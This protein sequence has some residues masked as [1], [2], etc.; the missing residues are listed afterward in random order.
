MP[1]FCWLILLSFAN[2]APDGPIRSIV[3]DGRT[4]TIDGAALR[5]DVH[6]LGQ[7]TA[8]PSRRCWAVLS[9]RLTI[10]RSRDV[11]VYHRS[12]VEVLCESSADRVDHV[13]SRSVQPHGLHLEDGDL[14]I[15]NRVWGW[16]RALFVDDLGRWLRVP[17]FQD[18]DAY[19]PSREV[20]GQVSEACWVVQEQFDLA[21]T[22]S[23]EA[24]RDVGVVCKA[25]DGLEV[26][27]TRR[28]GSLHWSA[29]DVM[30]A[31]RP[32]GEGVIERRGTMPSVRVE[33]RTIHIG[34]EVWD[35][36]SAE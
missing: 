15:E 30:N 8:D 12:S 19:A 10:A 1:T 21:A 33:G 17:T 24:I 2:A 23:Y 27:A 31:S 5:G 11:R 9:D 28:A 35:W 4:R 16:S 14:Y 6:V 32:G 36:T 25:G 22:G 18:Q 34:D 3:L 20:L 29:Q 7:L 13:T 26:R